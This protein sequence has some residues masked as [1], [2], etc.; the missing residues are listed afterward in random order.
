MEQKQRC[1]W[2]ALSLTNIASVFL[3][4]LLGREDAEY[5]H[6][7]VAIST[8]GSNERAQKW[9]KDNKI[10]D[11][12]S[13]VVYNS[14]VRLMNRSD[15]NSGRISDQLIN[16]WPKFIKIVNS[17]VLNREDGNTLSIP[18]TAGC[19]NRFQSH[20]LRQRPFGCLSDCHTSCAGK[21][22]LQ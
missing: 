7:L 14:S 4:D 13:I 5:E 6:K 17:S 11:P 3:P 20:P 21:C 19:C 10:P 18:M 9:F 12:D 22:R 2:A 8:T 15:L 16:L 1:R